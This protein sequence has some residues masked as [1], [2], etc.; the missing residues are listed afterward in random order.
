M[1]ISVKAIVVD[2]DKIWLRKNERNDW[3]LPGGRLDEGEQPEETVTREIQEELG[4]KLVSLRLVDVYIWKKN[5]GTSS[6]VAIVTFSGILAHKNG[7]FEEDGEAGK[8]E[9]KS[10][11]IQDALSLD[12]LPEVYKRAIK[13]IG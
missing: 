6:H 4:M 9:F 8:A 13:K 5:F 2:D 1:T 11:A 10:F 12:N 3:E 7:I